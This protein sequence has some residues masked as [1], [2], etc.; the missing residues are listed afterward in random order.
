MVDGYFSLD[1]RK[2]VNPKERHNSRVYYHKRNC[3]LLL[4]LLDVLN[5]INLEPLCILESDYQLALHCHL[6]TSHLIVEVKVKFLVPV[7]MESCR[8]ELVQIN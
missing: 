8:L 7:I 3:W 6:H 5:F 1:G 2:V 4:F